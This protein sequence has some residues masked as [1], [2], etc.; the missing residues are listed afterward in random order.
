MTQSRNDDLRASARWTG[1]DDDHD[2]YNLIFEEAI[3]MLAR[4]E[5]AVPALL[6]AVINAWEKDERS[7]PLPILA[8]ALAVAEESKVIQDLANAIK[9]KFLAPGSA[10]A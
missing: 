3:N 9:I 10:S 6:M 2:T 7:V 8:G 5:R 4:D 1:H